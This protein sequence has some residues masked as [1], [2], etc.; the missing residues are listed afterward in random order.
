MSRDDSRKGKGTIQLTHVHGLPHLEKLEFCYPLKLVAP[1]AKK[2]V[3]VIYVLSYGGGLVGGDSIRLDVEVEAGTTL[4]LTT[5]GST[6]VFK[7][8]STG[9]PTEQ[10]LHVRIHGI[11]L[12]LPDPVQPF[13]NSHYQQE[14]G[15][16]LDEHGSA[17][18]L[19]WIVSGRPDNGERWIFHHY[20]SANTLYRQGRMLVRDCQDMSL[21]LVGR[22][23]RHLDCMAT[24]LLVGPAFEADAD[25]I[26]QRFSQEN[27]IVQSARHGARH[28]DFMWTAVTHRGVTVI[29]VA[30]ISSEQVRSWLARLVD[31]QSWRERFGRDPFRALE[32]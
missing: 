5:Q 14:Q 32:M 21:A 23:M 1:K 7:I 22:Q 12:L 30:G 16:D 26:R 17:I 6:K 4:S 28:D 2:G 13:A 11:L 24:L 25:A 10:I 3:Q 9:L 15:F 31:S 18:V 29:K 8:R 27:R 20:R 19:D